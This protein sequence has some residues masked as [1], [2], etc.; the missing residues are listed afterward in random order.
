M[1]ITCNYAPFVLN[2][3]KYSLPNREFIRKKN[4]IYICEL[5]MEMVL[6]DIPIVSSAKRCGN[7]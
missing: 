4:M 1:S 3:S 2:T 5:V 7:L 6:K